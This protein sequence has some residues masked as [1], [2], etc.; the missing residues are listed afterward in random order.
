MSA[1]TVF[2]Q[3]AKIPRTELP[4][5]FKHLVADMGKWAE[6]HCN[7]PNRV[8]LPGSDYMERP[9]RKKSN[10]TPKEQKEVLDWE[11]TLQD[12]FECGHRSGNV[13]EFWPGEIINLGNVLG[14][15]FE[16]ESGA[17]EVFTRVGDWRCYEDELLL[18]Q[19][20]E[21]ALWLMEIEELQKA[22]QG[23]GNLPHKKIEA[24]TLELLRRDLAGRLDLEA[25][26]DAA[27]TD[28]TKHIVLPFKQ[29]VERSPR[30]DLKSTV[31]TINEALSAAATLC[32]T[33]IEMGNPI[34]LLW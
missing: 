2:A 29:N 3:V 22:F 28:S 15:I 4:C 20:D 12:M 33:G 23:F 11:H 5:R 16:S 24:L 34:R 7:C 19:P 21:A 30:P 13:I 31:E 8:P 9:H 18:I 6:V 14:R 10:L 1:P 26:L 17:F 32:H 25:R 27:L